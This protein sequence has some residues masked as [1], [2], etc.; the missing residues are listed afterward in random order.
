L[1]R[2]KCGR[3][4]KDETTIAWNVWKIEK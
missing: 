4:A 2:F 1:K 3:V